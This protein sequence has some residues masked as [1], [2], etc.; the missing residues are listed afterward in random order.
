MS[1]LDILK[2]CAA[3]VYNNTKD[4]IGTVEGKQKFS[5]GA[6]GDISTHI[7]LIA[8]KS[9]FEILK[10][11][12]FIPDVMGEECGFVKGS[13]SGLIVM[14]GIDGT[15][16]AN[17]G[18]PFYCCSLAY[19]TTSELD[20]VTD[21]VVFNLVNGDMYHASKDKG[22]FFNTIKLNLPDKSIKR[23][24]EEMVIGLNISGLPSNLFSSIANLISNVNHIRH[25]G[26]NA[27]EVC[28]F[29]QGSIDA[30]IDIRNKIRAIDMAACYLIAKEAGGLVLDTSGNEL[31]C[32]LSVD[33]RM[34]YMAVPN[35]N[36]YNW[37][38]DLIK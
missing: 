21:A 8:E 14:D 25:L 9:V 10:K 27:L 30:Y 4:I 18:L 37:I 11:N 15:T 19:S 34:S 16:N 13:N 32:S 31:N 1:T 22:S 26:A 35:T 7:D 2:E 38:H 20:S 33:S 3:N 6:G 5:L 12:S 28:Y 23:E 17:C 29:A 24:R 36:V